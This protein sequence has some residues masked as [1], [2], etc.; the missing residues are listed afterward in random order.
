MKKSFPILVQA[1]NNFPVHVPNCPQ[2]LHVY[3]GRGGGK[4]YTCYHLLNLDIGIKDNIFLYVFLHNFPK[5]MYY[6]LK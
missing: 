4:L 5:C 3:S 1:R 2:T 6:F